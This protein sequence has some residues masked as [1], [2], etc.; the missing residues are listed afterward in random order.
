LRDVAID[1]AVLVVWRLTFLFVIEPA[2]FLVARV[3]VPFVIIIYLV[4]EMRVKQAR[5]KAFT[6]R[7]LEPALGIFEGLWFLGG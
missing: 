7:S 1:F 2:V 3:W 4:V 5:D 6:Q